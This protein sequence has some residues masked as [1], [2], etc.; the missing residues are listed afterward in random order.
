M[1]GPLDM[2]GSATSTA[3]DDKEAAPS[4][5]DEVHFLLAFL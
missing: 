4:K 3:N 5:L 1:V 2:T